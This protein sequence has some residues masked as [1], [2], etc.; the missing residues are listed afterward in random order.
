[1]PGSTVPKKSPYQGSSYK[2]AKGYTYAVPN[3]SML[4]ILA[5]TPA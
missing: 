2:K 5:E 4:D 1:M 3:R